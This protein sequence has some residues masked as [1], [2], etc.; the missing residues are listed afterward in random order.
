MKISFSEVQRNLS[1]IANRESY[2]LDVLFEL[3]AAYGRSASSITKLR[4][5][6]LLRRPDLSS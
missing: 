5:G 2:T 3:M 1:E 4:T 6:A